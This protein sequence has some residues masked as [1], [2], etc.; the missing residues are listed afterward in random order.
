MPFAIAPRGLTRILRQA[1]RKYCL[2]ANSGTFSRSL[3]SWAVKPMPNRTF[4]ILKE[5]R[6]EYEKIQ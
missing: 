6:G 5:A 1:A 4:P 3:I 2:T